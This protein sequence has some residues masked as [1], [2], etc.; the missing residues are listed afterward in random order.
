MVEVRGTLFF[1]D[2]TK[3]NLRWPRQAGADSSTIATN[4]KNALDSDKMMVE[5]DNQLLVIPMRN[6]KY[7][8][9]SP[10]PEKLPQGV[11]KGVQI[12]D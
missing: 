6:V 1:M 9:I 5:V 10:A 4:I 8:Q 12:V 7:F 2:G 11:L 3:M